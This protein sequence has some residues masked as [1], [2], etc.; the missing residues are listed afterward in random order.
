[1]TKVDAHTGNFGNEFADRVAKRGAVSGEV[2][3]VSFHALP[4]I[5][6]HPVHGD[7]HPIEGDLHAYLK[8]QSQLW[9][10]VAWQYL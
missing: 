8:L 6:F 2:W 3:P 5:R 1:M 7:Q 10:S 4:D 9:V